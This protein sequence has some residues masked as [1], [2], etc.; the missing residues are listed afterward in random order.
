MTILYFILAALG[1]GILVFIHELGH[2]FVAKKTGMTVEIFSIGFGRPILKW[3]WQ[4]VDWQIGWLPFGGY[5]KILGMEVSKKEGREPHEIPN[6]FFSKSPWR[7]ISVA[8]A[9]PLAN[10]ILA[11]LI[12]SVLW[13]MGGREKPFSEYSQIIG[14]VEP[15]SE[16]YAEGVRPGDVL[17]EYN[18][19]AFTNSKDLLYASMLGGDDVELKGY[20]V[21]YETGEKSPFVHTIKPYPASG[22]ID[23]IMTTGITTMAR[24]LIYDK[25]PGAEANQ[26]PEGSPMEGSG[27][28]YGDRLVW[29]D[30]ELLFSM[31]Q[32]SHIIN[33]DLALLTVKRGSKIFLTRQPRVLAD[34]IN[35]P[36]YLKD[37][38][39][40]WQYEVGL[41]GRWEDLYILPF[42]VNSEGYVEKS[43][44]FI[45]E[46]VRK[47]LPM[48]G[49]PLEARDKI[50]AV[51]GVRVKKGFEILNLLQT[52]HVQL[53]AQKD[54]S[55]FT[56]MSWSTED[57]VFEKSINENHI[58][59]MAA[60][61]GT[62]HQLMHMGNYVML[63]PV[64]PKPLSKF[65]LS[66]ET[67][68]RL[69]LELYKQQEQVAAIK[70]REKRAAATKLLE[71]S[72]S[73]LLLGV[74]L[75]DRQVEFNPNPFAMFGQVFVETWHTLKALI[76]GYLHP[77]WL[78]GPIGIVRVMH[79]G[80]RVGIGE[81]LFWIGAISVN[82][83]FLN[84]MPIPVLDGGYIFLSI[85]EWITKKR[86]K[87]KTMERIVMPFVVLL[88]AL[89]CFLTF[90]DISRLF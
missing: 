14:Y 27:L 25:L 47:A 71:Q 86:L 52:H 34:E 33:D 23:E 80:W 60:T 88:I 4:N 68:E 59:A 43:L 11:F 44:S 7:R 84:L 78:S 66:A 18:G 81:A 69:K 50:L 58:N 48:S 37:E 5:V 75:Q 39:S 55:A 29:A 77:K 15:N 31:D 46:N 32:L 36:R 45:D 63:P 21:N 2:Y 22:A 83:G 12:F 67:K 3:R 79:H 28:N 74:Y 42:V 41:K 10:F 53:I 40:D 76:F 62:D 19:K 20:H 64:E 54:V 51:D 49:T 38:L 90:Q 16:L 17:T 85:W 9:G 6:G 56:K 87:A 57:N 82:L 26:F 73:K 65:D 70:D 8:F 13:I 1:L 61:I 35:M 89:L 24:Y 72:Q 30:G